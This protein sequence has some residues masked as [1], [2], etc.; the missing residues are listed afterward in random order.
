VD[1]L[2]ST[3]HLEAITTDLGVFV[4]GL[5]VS[6]SQGPDTAADLRGILH[7]HGLLVFKDQALDDDIQKRFA[8][9][10][11][12][13]HM[14]PYTE[15]WADPLVAVVNSDTSPA[16]DYRIDCWHTDASFEECPPSASVMR[17]SILPSSG[18]DTLWASMYAAYESLSSKLQRLIDELEAVH[19]SSAVMSRLPANRSESVMTGKTMSTVHPVA[20]VDPVTRRRALYVNS[21]YTTA[22]VGLKESESTRILDLLFDEVA[23]PDIQVRLQWAPGTLAVWEERITQHRAIGRHAGK[24]EVR[25]VTV[26]GDRP[27]GVTSA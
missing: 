14:Y 23:N 21:N 24:R 25:R 17:C 11:G 22:I 8:T 1:R 19:S 15:K 12:K 26:Q 13:L 3:I 6:S 18:G 5:D 9:N 2:T 20:V 27:L 16:H 4:A 10:F 7:E